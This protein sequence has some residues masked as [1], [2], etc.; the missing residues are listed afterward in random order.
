MAQENYRSKQEVL[1]A[2]AIDLLGILHKCLDRALFS[3]ILYKT[4]TSFPV[5][6]SQVIDE[7]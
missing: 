7:Y 4:S 5:P 3:C 2:R 1:N 6:T